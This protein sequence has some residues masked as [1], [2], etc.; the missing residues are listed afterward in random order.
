MSR[1][2]KNEIT[3]YKPDDKGLLTFLRSEIEAEIPTVVTQG[4]K[5]YTG[6][7]FEGKRVIVL[8]LRD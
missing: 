8:V 2:R 4:G 1:P 7:E 5:A 6:R 3:R